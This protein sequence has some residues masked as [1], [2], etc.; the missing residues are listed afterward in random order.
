MS[1]RCVRLGESGE[2]SKQ[3]SAKTWAINALENTLRNPARLPPVVLEFPISLLFLQSSSTPI[4]LSVSLPN[5]CI[6]CSYTRA[7]CED[8]KSQGRRECHSGKAPTFSEEA[9]LELWTTIRAT[10]YPQFLLE[11][12]GK[13]YAKLFEWCL[14]GQRYLKSR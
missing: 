5:P 8:G 14:E 6:Q 3:R 10:I 7:A 13:R 4:R 12:T 1:C 2:G 11:S 9:E